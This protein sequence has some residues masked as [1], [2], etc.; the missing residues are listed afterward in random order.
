[1]VGA[2]FCTQHERASRSAQDQRRGSP[3]E[4]GYDS[5]WRRERDRFIAA[6]P[7]CQKCDEDGRTV[8]A[9]DVDHV[10]P[11][12]L[13]EAKDS[14]D[15]VRIAAAMKLFWSR[16]NWQSLCKSCHSIVK[17]AEERALRRM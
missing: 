5:K 11:H 12:R 7:L 3:A 6:H 8:A 15:P 16:T 1:V 13:K 9:T 14:G 17:Q 2:R 4:R 10:V